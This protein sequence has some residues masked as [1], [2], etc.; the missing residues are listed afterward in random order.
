MFLNIIVN[1]TKTS[2]DIQLKNI[3][4]LIVDLLMAL[5]ADSFSWRFYRWR[6]ARGY[7]A[8]KSTSVR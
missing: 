5:V 2:S 8:S 1:P 4:L 6:K 7:Q 3:D